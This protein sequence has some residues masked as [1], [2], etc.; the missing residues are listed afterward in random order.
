MA[1]FMES[2]IIEKHKKFK[3][4][5]SKRYLNVIFIHNEM[6]P[7]VIFMNSIKRS[8]ENIMKYFD[9]TKLNNLK[10]DEKF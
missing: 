7:I 2:H 4:L 1:Y 9:F 3:V 10:L 5:Y 6:T 8:H